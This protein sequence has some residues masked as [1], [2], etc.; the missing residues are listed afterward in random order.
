MNLVSKNEIDSSSS[1]DEKAYDNFKSHLD[2]FYFLMDNIY[3]RKF[4][5]VLLIISLLV[6]YLLSYFLEIYID[7]II[8]IYEN[9]FLNNVPYFESILLFEN[10]ILIPLILAVVCVVIYIRIK[11]KNTKK[12]TEFINEYEKYVLN[13]DDM[14][15]Y[16]DLYLFYNLLLKDVKS[17]KILNRRNYPFIKSK[18][19]K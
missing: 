18:K 19:I 10:G 12:V 8:I 16:Q 1:K 6:C 13:K 11:E 15:H 14:N 5:R 2:N 3:L 7:D 4:K 17:M 9:T